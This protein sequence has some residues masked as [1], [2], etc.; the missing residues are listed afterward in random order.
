MDSAE[1]LAILST[2]DTRRRQGKNKVP[3]Q[4]SKCGTNYWA[5]HWQFRQTTNKQVNIIWMPVIIKLNTTIIEMWNVYPITILIWG[6]WYLTPL[7][8]KRL[9][10]VTLSIVRAWLYVPLIMFTYL[11]W[12]WSYGSWIYSYLCNQWLSPL[13]L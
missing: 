12:S 2:Q 5:F 8:A 3:Y 6:G 9:V 7:C 1:T 13:M 4:T 10:S 11:S